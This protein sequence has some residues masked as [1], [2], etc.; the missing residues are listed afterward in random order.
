MAAKLDPTGR[1]I[2]SAGEFVHSTTFLAWFLAIN[3]FLGLILGNGSESYIR[4]IRAPHIRPASHFSGRF[5][6][7]PRFSPTPLAARSRYLSFSCVSYIP[8][9]PYDY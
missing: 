4:T 6:L 1:P 3:A 9:F 8:F 2:V 7:Q 5:S